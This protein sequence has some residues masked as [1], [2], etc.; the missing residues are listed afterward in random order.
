MKE[1]QIHLFPIYLYSCP[2]SSELNVLY[3]EDWVDCKSVIARYSI[4]DTRRPVTAQALGPCSLQTG[5]GSLN[6]S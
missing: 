3:A 4:F 2:P 5:K 1:L 6:H